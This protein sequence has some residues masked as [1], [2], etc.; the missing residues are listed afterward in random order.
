MRGFVANA[1][2]QQQVVVRTNRHQ[3]DERQARHTPVKFLAED[4]LE[5]NDAHAQRGQI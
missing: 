4:E 5:Q 2:Y 1:G 3:D